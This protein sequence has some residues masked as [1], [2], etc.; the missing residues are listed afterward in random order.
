SFVLKEMFWRDYH[1][2]YFYS[3]LLTIIVP[4]L[5]FLFAS[6]SF[7]KILGFSGVVFSGFQGILLILMYYRAKKLGERQPA[8]RFSLHPVVAVIICLIFATALIYQLIY[9]F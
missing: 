5:I 4:P 6:Q 3:W 8:W 7:V 9:S 2:P 1:L